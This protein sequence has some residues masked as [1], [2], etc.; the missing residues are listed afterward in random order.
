MA[1]DSPGFDSPCRKSFFTFHLSPSMKP[2][3]YMW[4]ASVASNS[5]STPTTMSSSLVAR[6]AFNKHVASTLVRRS[7]RPL[8]VQAR[9][10]ADTAYVPGGPIY[11]GSVNDPTTFPPPSK[12]HGSYHWAFER[13][14]SAGLVPLTAAAFVT[15]GSNYPMLDGILGVSLVMHSHIGF[16]AILVDYLHPRKFPILGR[17]LSWTLR[18]TTVGVLVGVYQFN[19]QDI[20]LTELITKVWHA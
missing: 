11:R 2:P 20:G 16:D 14:L 15:S 19:T 18:A 9:G 6:S 1:R 13:L 10:A 7:L 5:T 12:T 17:A 3:V 8:T 4:V